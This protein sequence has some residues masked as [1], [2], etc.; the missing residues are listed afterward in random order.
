M[1]M[2]LAGE[3]GRHVQCS[4]WENLWL[5]EWMQALKGP[6]GHSTSARLNGAVWPHGWSVV[7]CLGNIGCWECFGQGTDQ[8]LNRGWLYLSCFTACTSVRCEMERCF[9]LIPT[10]PETPSERGVTARDQPLVTATLKHLGLSVSL[11]GRSTDFFLHFVG[12][13][14]WISN[15]LPLFSQ[16]AGYLLKTKWRRSVTTLWVNP[17]EDVRF[18]VCVFNSNPHFSKNVYYCQ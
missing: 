9:L 4:L 11:K 1:G 12:S 6:W 15:F 16:E 3:W 17:W 8:R 14:I 13:G 2:G 7:G 10:P 18:S 5:C